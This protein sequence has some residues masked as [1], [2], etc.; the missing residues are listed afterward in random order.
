VLYFDLV[1][2]EKEHLIDKEAIRNAIKN[3]FSTDR[4]TMPGKP[5][6]GC[7]VRRFVFEPLDY[8]LT[9]DIK[10]QIISAISI[11][12]PRIEITDVTIEEVPEY[13]RVNVSITYEFTFINTKDFDTIT[14]SF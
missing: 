13:N 10:A 7:N 11:Y 6:F 1:D 2:C 14:L 4:G 12:E 8:V 3:I 5:Q 9:N